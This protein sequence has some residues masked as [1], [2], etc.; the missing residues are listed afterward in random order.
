MKCEKYV[1]NEKLGRLLN[2]LRLSGMAVHLDDL[3]IKAQKEKIAH[4]DF[5]LSLLEVE[6]QQRTMR[7]LHNKFKK[8]KLPFNWDLRSFPFEHQP[9]V[10]RCQ[11]NNLAKLDFVRKAMN[12]SFIGKSGTGKTGLAVGLFRL[13]LTHGFTGKFYDAQALLDELYASLA[14]RTT[15]KLLNRLAR[16]DVLVIDSLKCLQCN[17]EQA[18]L[19]FQ[20]IDKRYQKRSTIITTPFDY[21]KWYAWFKHKELTDALIDRFCHYCITVKIDGSSLRKPT[22]L[23]TKTN[24]K[25]VKA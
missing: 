20:L 6:H 18:N 22:N 25:K 8:A 14:D 24:K 21:P 15:K 17:T 1:M 4:S 16:C 2:D 7:Y 12:I 3:L 11:I 19:F 23:T 13:A 9:D 5:L 10:D